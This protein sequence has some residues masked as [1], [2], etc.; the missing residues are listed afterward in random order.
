MH[1]VLGP[2]DPSESEWS[3]LNTSTLDSLGILIRLDSQPQ[4]MMEHESTHSVHVSWRAGIG[5]HEE[6]EEE[7]QEGTKWKQAKMDNNT[8]TKNKHALWLWVGGT[9]TVTREP[10]TRSL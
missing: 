6:G 5:G 7:R 9:A 3:C 8:K 1:I 4:E 2:L 10:S